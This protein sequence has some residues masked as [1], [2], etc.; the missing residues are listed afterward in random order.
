LLVETERQLL[1]SYLHLSSSFRIL[2]DILFGYNF[3]NTRYI[4][5]VI[6]DFDIILT[7]IVGNKNKKAMLVK[8][9][10]GNNNSFYALKYSTLL[11]TGE[12]KITV[13]DG[14]F[15]R[16]KMTAYEPDDI[17]KIDQLQVFLESVII[18]G[19]KYD[20]EILPVLK[21]GIYKIEKVNIKKAILDLRDEMIKNIEH[22]Q[23]IVENKDKV[24]DFRISKVIL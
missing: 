23:P 14:H 16:S 6:Y 18:K 10:K 3:N 22:K 20:A 19:K 11:F 15:E 5:D 12:Y 8:S 9:I 13:G 24:I 21:S 7:Q 17:E 4:K 1:L 2:S